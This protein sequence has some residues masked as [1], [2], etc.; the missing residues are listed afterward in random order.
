ML[1]QDMCQI[2]EKAIKSAGNGA[3]LQIGISCFQ[4]AVLSITWHFCIDDIDYNQ[5]VIT[6]MHIAC[7]HQPGY[8]VQMTFWVLQP[9][10]KTW[11]KYNIFYG[12]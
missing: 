5:V 3:R 4:F 1:N 9:L 6:P 2:L 7:R 8:L 10:N 12:R 11:L